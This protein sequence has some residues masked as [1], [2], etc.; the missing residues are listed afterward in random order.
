MAVHT[1]CAGKLKRS[2]YEYTYFSKA[3]FTILDI[4]FTLMLH[5]CLHKPLLRR[6]SLCS[7]HVSIYVVE[8]SH[9]EKNKPCR[10]CR[11]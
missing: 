1:G 9:V 5:I 6:E 3:F 4:S 2:D 8:A 11:S 7:K 10:S